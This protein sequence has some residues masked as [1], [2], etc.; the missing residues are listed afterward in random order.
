MNFTQM[1]DSKSI[2]DELQASTFDFNVY[3]AC[4]KML[5]DAKKA[6]SEIHDTM[7]YF[8]MLYNLIKND[9]YDAAAKS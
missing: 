1:N 8:N 3:D 5:K 7:E 4:I 6:D 2:D 9:T